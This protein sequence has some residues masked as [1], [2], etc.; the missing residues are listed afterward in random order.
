[1][2][3]ESD[4]PNGQKGLAVDLGKKVSFDPKKMPTPLVIPEHG[5]GF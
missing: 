2:R 1:M 4:D 3:I 5:D